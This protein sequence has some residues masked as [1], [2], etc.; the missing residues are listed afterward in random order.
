VQRRSGALGAV[1]FTDIVDSTTVAAE[2]GNARWSELVARHHRIV[3]QH[4]ARWRGREID[5]AG[6]GFF[7]VFERPADAIRCAVAS[8]EAVRELGIEIRAGVS[9]GELDRSG[10]K[11]SGLVVNTAA[12]VMAIAER[13]EVLVPLS[14]KEIVSGVGISFAPN[15]IHRLK[16]LDGAFELFRVTDVDGTPL[17]LPLD[18]ETAAERRREIFPT[19]RRRIPLIV[20][21]A[22]GALA[23]ITVGALVQG[24]G[25]EPQGD[26]GPLRNAIARIDVETGRVQAP[27]FLGDRGIDSHDLTADIDRLMSVGEGGVWLLQPPF[28]V[29]VDPLH[30]EVRSDQILV[31]AAESQAV[32]TGLGKIWV[33]SGRTLYEV[34]PLTDEATISYELPG[35][36]ALTTSSLAVGDAVW[37]GTSD[38]NLIRHDPFTRGSIEADVG[39]SIDA[40][41]AT[42]HDVWLADL[43]RGMVIRVDPETLDVVG[44]PLEIRG[45][46]DQIGAIGRTVWVLD[47]QVGQV[48]RIDADSG[49]FRDARVGG[50]P[51]E[52]AVTEDAVWVGDRDG[53]LYRVDAAT[54]EV[55]PYP[56]GAEVLSV[57]VDAEGS[58]WIYVGDPAERMAA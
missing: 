26:P 29:H 31:G 4:L 28:L 45:N 12:R 3:R 24:I 1:L 21:L 37:I 44:E 16:G 30:E 11:P 13:G 57:D 17:A 9:F 43:L 33:L 25:E 23:L 15:G 58:P 6:D 34:H 20:G 32:H 22:A 47:K 53:S 54:L 35:R 36:L 51:T 41:T 2:M 40:I 50:E 55:T 48:T 39:S 38:G 10:P 18:E 49:R 46:L 42:E 27:L 14:V 7:V 19:R 8:V 52:M 5:T 56:V